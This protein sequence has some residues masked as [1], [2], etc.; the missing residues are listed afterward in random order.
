MAE[1]AVSVRGFH[2]RS[3]CSWLDASSLGYFYPL[4]LLHLP[5]HTGRAFARQHRLALRPSEHR[6]QVSTLQ[7][8]VLE[9]GALPL[10]Y[11]DTEA[12]RL[13]SEGFQANDESLGAQGL[14]SLFV[15]YRRVIGTRRG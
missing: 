2:E 4:P 14:T 13:F 15:D 8:P 11:C 7:P 3:S 10:S 1:P 6:R 9:T 5:D 12:P